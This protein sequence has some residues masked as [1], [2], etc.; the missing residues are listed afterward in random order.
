MRKWVANK[1]VPTRCPSDNSRVLQSLLSQKDQ[2]IIKDG[3]LFRSRLAT[4]ADDR[5][6][7][8][9]VVPQILRQEI[10]HGL[11]SGPEG[12]HLGKKKT[13][14]NR[15][16]QRFYWPD[17][18]EDVADWCRKCQECSQRKNGSKR[19]QGQLHPHTAPY[20]MSRI[21]VDII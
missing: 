6:G 11:H 9:F 3:I 1:T 10:L 18:S 2:M 7:Y 12:G 21:G 8:Q 16:P 4:H 5:A 13:L 14:W 19:H 20:P 17:L 15:V